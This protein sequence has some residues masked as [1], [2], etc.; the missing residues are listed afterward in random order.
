MN[1][2]REK[3]L[4]VDDIPENLNLLRQS[5]EAAGYDLLFATSGEVALNIAA[6]AAPDLILLDIIMPGIDGF[7]TCRRL[8]SD[9]TTQDI[10]VIF[11]TAKDET[12]EVVE[13]FRIGGVDYIIKPFEKEEILARVETHLKNA[14]L[15]KALQQKNT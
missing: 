3:I 14:R 9:K 13:G 10:P 5:L 15:T 4:I 11:I 12:K 8:K 2:P 6:R 7:E 1:Q